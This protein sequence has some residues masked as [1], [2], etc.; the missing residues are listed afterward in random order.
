M[1]KAEI[2]IPFPLAESSQKFNRVETFTIG[3]K[4]FDI[5]IPLGISVGQKLRLRGI[6]HHIHPTLQNDDVLLLVLPSS[7]M[8]YPS[9]RDVY[10]ELPLDPRQRERGAIQRVTLEDK[11]FD[12][13]V[14]AGIEFGKKMRMGDMARLYNGG[15]PGDIFLKIVPINRPKKRFFGIFSDFDVPVGRK[16]VFKFGIPG[17]FEIGGEWEYARSLAE[18]KFGTQ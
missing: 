11:K 6:A 14:P 5:K 18:I 8:I 17:L 12:I 4:Q 9:K 3:Q 7:F 2:I 1:T 10:L 13:K 16:V 15:Y